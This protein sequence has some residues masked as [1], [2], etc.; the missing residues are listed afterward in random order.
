MQSVA[1]ILHLSIFQLW[2]FQLEGGHLHSLQT[3][4]C[5]EFFIGGQQRRP[6]AGRGSWRRAV[7]PSPPARGLSIGERGAPPAGF[8]A[9]LRPPKSLPLFSALRMASPDTIIFLIVDYQPAIRG[10]RP[11]FSPLRTPVCRPRT[12]D[13]TPSS[14]SQTCDCNCFIA[15]VMLALLI[16]ID[17]FQFDNTWYSA[18]SY[19]ITTAEALRY[20]T[21]SVD[22]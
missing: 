12:G 9:E 20:G 10:P 3:R 21:C 7:I 15:V 8:G 2:T 4:A 14:R 6:T 18:S 16:L 17:F 11:P 19:C 22:V 1:E 5:P 13:W